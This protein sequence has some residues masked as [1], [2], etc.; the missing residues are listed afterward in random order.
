MPKTRGCPKRC[1]SGKHGSLHALTSV[2]DSRR[3]C[4]AREKQFQ[5]V[6]SNDIC[7]VFFE[8]KKASM[9]AMRDIRTVPLDRSFYFLLNAWQTLWRPCVF[10]Q[11]PKTEAV[12]SILSHWF[13]M[14][15]QNIER[16]QRSQAL[17]DAAKHIKEACEIFQREADRL[18]E[19][20]E[21]ID[22]MSKKLDQVHFS[23]T[24]TLPPYFFSPPLWLCAAFQ[25]LNA[26]NRLELNR[27]L[28][29]FINTYPRT[30]NLQHWRNAVS[31]RY[32][33]RAEITVFMFQLVVR[34]L[35]G[36]KSIRYFVNITLSSLLATPTNASINH[37]IFYSRLSNFLDW[38]TPKM[39]TKHSFVAIVY[40]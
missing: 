29:R 22:A 5:T 30:L 32:I 3:T 27:P 9:V 21:S 16:Q 39:L 12:P 40:G 26:W 18:H 14:S 35:S 4:K 25:I 19:E 7:K 11:L 10:T 13:N 8:P 23:S 28:H 6:R 33:N 15:E 1:D 37:A 31:L 17:V 34:F 20:Q 38:V 24:V 36:V 2:F